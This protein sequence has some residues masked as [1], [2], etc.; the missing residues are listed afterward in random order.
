MY[1]IIRRYKTIRASQEL[2]PRIASWPRSTRSSHDRFQHGPSLQDFIQKSQPTSSIKIHQVSRAADVPYVPK[3]VL[4]GNNRKIFFEVYGCQMNT[5]DTEIVWSI[6]QS[7]N[8]LRTQSIDDADIVLVVTCAIREGAEARVWT[9]LKQIRALKRN[10]GKWSPLQ[11]GVLGCMAERL[12]QQLVE[13]EQVVDVVAGPDSY[14]DLPRLL[15]TGQNGQ[16]A[17]NVLLSLDETYADVMP[18]KLD[19]NSRTAFVSIMRGCDNM[20]SYCIVPFTRG[21]ERSRPIS[22]IKEEILHLEA[23]GIKEITLLGQNVNSYRDTSREPEGEKQATVIV[24][25]FKTVY[26]TKIGGL[27]FSDLL[28]ELAETVPEVRIRFTSPHPKDFPTRLLETIAKY[29][30]ICNSFHLPAQSGSSTVLERM[31]RGYTREAYLSLVNEIRSIIPNVTLSSDF[32]CGFCGE[33]DE[34][35][36]ETISLLREIKYHVAY[37]FA[38]SMREKTTA[39]RRFKDDVPDEVKKQRLQEMFSVFRTGAQELNA[40]FVGQLQLILVEGSSKRSQDDLYGRNDGNI[41]VIIPSGMIPV[42]DPRSDERKMITAGDYVV[43]RIT[44]SNS[45]TLKGMPL[46]HTTIREFVEYCTY[47]GTRTEQDAARAAMLQRATRQNVERYRLKRRQQTHLFREKKRRL[48]EKECEEMELLYCSRESRKFFKKLNASHKGFVPRA[49]MCRNKEGGILTNER[50]VIE[51]WRQHYDE[52]LNSAQTGDLDGAEEDYTGAM[53]NDDVPPP[54]MGEVKEA[55]N[56]LKN[57]RAA[58][59]DGLV[60]ELFKGGP[61]KLV[62]CMHR[63]IVRIWDTEQLPEE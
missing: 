27:R 39:H 56:Q 49:E 63:L 48:E 1:N 12:K 60:A 29:P 34:E 3:E 5:S 62:E 25:G 40:R 41:K 37:L 52:H 31:R 24:P 58:G 30:N 23:L 33:T 61:R 57:H 32:I 7:H 50:D 44:E 55:I 19:Q 16:K 15:A 47:S 10:R 59:K 9:R 18:V 51:R 38:Y 11:I 36:A 22:S 28:S 4:L 2:L 42:R 26:K 35:F 43:A 45:Q 14:K 20:C 46:Y 53:N 6:L 8:Y 21:K 54:T 13:K 17:I